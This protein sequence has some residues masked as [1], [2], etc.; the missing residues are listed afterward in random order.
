ME[1]KHEIENQYHWDSIVSAV[2][3]ITCITWKAMNTHNRKRELVTARQLVMHFAA[4]KLAW[5]LKEI[6]RKFNQTNIDHSVVIYSR[7]KIND[8]LDTD[9]KFVTQY[10]KIR[11]L[12]AEP[13]TQEFNI[14]ID[15]M[16]LLSLA[17]EN[18]NL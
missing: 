5:S 8:Y 2:E 12:I 4:Y 1:N 15:S 7:D 18:P 3:T 14:N 11:D 6:A 13:E 10:N 17:H 16:A 9:R